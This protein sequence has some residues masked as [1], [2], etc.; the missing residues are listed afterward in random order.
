MCPL[1][2]TCPRQFEYPAG[3]SETFWGMV[4]KHSRLWHHLMQKFRPRVEPGFNLT[5]NK[6]GVTDF[7]LNSRHLTR[8]LS[9]LNDTLET[10]E[11]LAVERP[12]RPHQTRK[13]LIGDI[14]QPE[15]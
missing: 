8:A 3:L 9:I 7:F 4:P 12:S 14:F 2:G 13:A 5:K 10:L 11:I 15:L 6:Y 1:R